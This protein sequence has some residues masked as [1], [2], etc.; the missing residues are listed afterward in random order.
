MSP[1][2]PLLGVSANVVWSDSSGAIL[3][4]TLAADKLPGPETGGWRLAAIELGP[5]AGAKRVADKL[6]GPEAGGFALADKPLGPEAGGRR[7]AVKLL[8]PAAGARMTEDKEL[9]PEAGGVTITVPDEHISFSL[10]NPTLFKERL[11]TQSDRS[12]VFADFP[13]RATKAIGPTGLNCY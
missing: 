1:A 5:A 11:H 13:Q 4:V 6:P 9:G 3:R 12:A 2:D 8:G 10:T 7:V